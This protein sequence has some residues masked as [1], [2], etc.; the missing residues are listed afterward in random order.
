MTSSP[1]YVVCI[2]CETP[3]YNFEWAEDNLREA[4]C[5]TCGNDDLDRFATPEEFEAMTGG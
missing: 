3:S 1:E 4:F 2:E 5:E